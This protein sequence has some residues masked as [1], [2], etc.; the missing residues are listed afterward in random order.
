MTRWGIYSGGNGFGAFQAGVNAYIVDTRGPAYLDVVCG[1]SAGAIN[2][3][4]YATATVPEASTMWT[5]IE[6]S[7]IIKRRSLLQ[8]GLSVAASR[9]MP[10]AKKQTGFYDTAPLL[11]TLEEFFAGAVL[12]R[13]LYAGR[14]D[15]RTGSY[16]DYVNP[17]TIARD[18]WQSTLIPIMMK[19]DVSNTSLWVDGGIHNASPLS[20]VVSDGEE[21]DRVLIISASPLKNKPKMM[22][23]P[24]KSVDVIDIAEA[25]IGYML[26]VAAIN[27]M[28][29]FMERNQVEGYKHFET[30]VIQ[31]TVDLGNASDYR[32]DAMRMRFAHGYE[33]AKRALAGVT[34]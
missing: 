21:G 13:K 7:Q 14:V 1:I 8:F 20:R 28:K 33:S 9:L 18:V 24:P 30:I 19:A 15:L 34:F 12:N 22:R 27:D 10:W 5:E 4:A 3:A 11:E 31:P 32:K 26:D 23:V 6:E 2:A 16:L 25:T 29:R 17:R